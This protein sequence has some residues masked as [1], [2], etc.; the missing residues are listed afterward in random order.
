ME[1]ILNE[2]SNIKV[3]GTINQIKIAKS[4]NNNYFICYLLN[5]IPSCYIN[6][7]EN[8]KR[9]LK[10]IDCNYKTDFDKNY[11]VLYFK[12]TDDFM[13]ISRKFLATT[14]LSNGNKTT[15]VCNKEIF[16]VQTNENSIIY[17]N[18]YK[19]V[20]YSNFSNYM[21]CKNITSF[22]SYNNI[23]Y[24]QI[25]ENII[26]NMNNK[27]ELAK[28]ISEYII[29]EINIYNINEKQEL[30]VKKD[31]MTITFSSIDN[32]KENENKNSTTIFSFFVLL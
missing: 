9:E 15:K 12:D 10:K 5:N 27:S 1:I 18:G 14:L 28:E 21:I 30:I 11:K 8:S 3:E 17:N 25:F 2:T 6:L 19:V 16:S 13:F 4:Y 20:N 7:K 29:N 24:S 23:N 26:Y 32:Q 22:I 31:E